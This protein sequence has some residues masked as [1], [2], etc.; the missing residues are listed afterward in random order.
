[1]KNY[2]LLFFGLQ[3]L[4][5]TE[6][7]LFYIVGKII[8]S[9]VFEDFIR[10]TLLVNTMIVLNDP[11]KGWHINHAIV[12]PMFQGEKRKREEEEEE[13]ME[14]FEI[15]LEKDEKGLGLTVAGYICEKGN[16]N[17]S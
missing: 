16:Y 10:V 9:L 7:I 11:A 8:Y 15:K 4:H 3:N 14:L 13:Q 6:S 1:M 2:M 5:H 12:M 17:Q